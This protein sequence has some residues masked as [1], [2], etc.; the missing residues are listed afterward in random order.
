MTMKKPLLIAAVI[1]LTFTP[2]VA[3]AH[4][5]EVHDKNGYTFGTPAKESDATRTIEIKASD[6]KFTPS[7]ITIK[8]GE[9]IKFVVTNTERHAHDFNIG[10]VAAQ[11]EHAQMMAKMPDMQH[12]DDDPTTRSINRGETKTIA[13]TFNK[14]PADPIEIDCLEPGHY[15]KGMTIK[16]TLSN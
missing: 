13:W 15:E 3:Y 5:D 9:T 10:D 14:R 1:A 11:Q 4:D 8:Q 2:F 12:G 6:D 7:E 16:I